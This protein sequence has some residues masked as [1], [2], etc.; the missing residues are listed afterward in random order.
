LPPAWQDIYVDAATGFGADITR[1]IRPGDDHCEIPFT[2][3][4]DAARFLLDRLGV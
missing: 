4:H 3:G 1:D 2:A